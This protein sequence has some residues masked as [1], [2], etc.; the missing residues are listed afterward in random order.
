M[1]QNTSIANVASRFPDEGG[2]VGLASSDGLVEID[3]PSGVFDGAGRYQPQSGCWR[4]RD[5]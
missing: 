3:V 2:A 1:F 5:A 4:M